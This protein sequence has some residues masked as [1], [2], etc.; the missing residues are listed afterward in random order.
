MRTQGIAL[1]VAAATLALGTR[2][3]A[4]PHWV[5]EAREHGYYGYGP[6]WGAPRPYVHFGWYDPWRA[7]RHALENELLYQGAQWLAGTLA[8]QTYVAPPPPYYAPPVPY[9]APPATYAV[10]PPAYYAAPPAPYYAPPPAPYVA[11]A[12]PVY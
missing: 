12:L 10:P 5:H 6:G 2:A 9:V 1:V 7:Q 8:P 3:T 11:P 4:D